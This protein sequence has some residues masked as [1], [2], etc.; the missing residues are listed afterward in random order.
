MMIMHLK[1]LYFIYF[2]LFEENIKIWLGIELIPKFHIN[3]VNANLKICFHVLSISN[4]C[5]K[6][7]EIIYMLEN[8]LSLIYGHFKSV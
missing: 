3:N 7:K 5:V 4:S 6:D 2:N 1:M 8:E